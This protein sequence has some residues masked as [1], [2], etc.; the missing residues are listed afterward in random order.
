MR[1]F[2]LAD[3]GFIYDLCDCGDFDAAEESANDLGITAVWLINEPS[4]AQWLERLASGLADQS[5]NNAGEPAEVSI[6][7]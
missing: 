3:D 6:E 4:A 2:A 1:Y 5:R 7:N